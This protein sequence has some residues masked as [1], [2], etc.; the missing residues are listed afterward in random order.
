MDVNKLRKLAAGVQ[1]LT[2]SKKRLMKKKIREIMTQFDN[3][4]TTEQA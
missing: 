3:T 2:L 1:P 4:E